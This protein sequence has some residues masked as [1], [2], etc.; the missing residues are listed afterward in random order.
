MSTRN[1][2]I[3]TAAVTLF[4]FFARGKDGPTREARSRRGRHHQH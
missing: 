3:I 2:A 4:A 1:I